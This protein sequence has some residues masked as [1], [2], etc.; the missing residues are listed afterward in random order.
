MQGADPDVQLVVTG[1]FNAFE[2]T[3]GYVDAGIITGDFTRRT[4]SSA[5][6]TPIPTCVD[7][8]LTDEVLGIPAEQRYSFIFRDTFNPAGSRGRPGPR[9]RA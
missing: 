3:D 2:F 6:P 1:D 7:P 8:D 4:T 9:P 5:T